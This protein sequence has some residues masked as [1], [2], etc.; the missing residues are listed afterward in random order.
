MQT[1][2]WIHIIIS[3]RHVLFR[4]VRSSLEIS[5]CHEHHIHSND[6]SDNIDNNAPSIVLFLSFSSENGYQRTWN[7]NIHHKL[8]FAPNH[9]DLLLLQYINLLGNQI[10]KSQWLQWLEWIPKGIFTIYLNYLFG[11]VGFWVTNCHL[12]SDFHRSSSS[13]NSRDLWMCNPFWDSIGVPRG[14]LC[15]HW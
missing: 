14:D 2:P 10:A 6:S 1:S 15:D 8:Y 3:A 7:C 12:W 9:N 11:M 13:V 5:G 4:P